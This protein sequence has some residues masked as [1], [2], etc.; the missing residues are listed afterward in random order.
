MW[1]VATRT[2]AGRDLMVLTDTPVDVLDFASPAPGL[3]GKLGIDATRKIGAET[4]RIWG[5]RLEMDEASRSRIDILASKLP[6]LFAS[7][8]DQP[9]RPS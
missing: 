6:D 3:G 1:A 9:R 8:P 4:S 2:D 5:H 7:H